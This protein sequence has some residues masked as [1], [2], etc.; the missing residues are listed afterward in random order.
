MRFPENVFD[1]VGGEDAIWSDDHADLSAETL[2][3]TGPHGEFFIKQGPVAVAEHERLRWLKRWASVPD[4]VAFEGDVLVLAEAG[5]RSLDH[6]PPPDAGTI[7][8]RALRELH[9]IPVAECPFDER[10]DVKLARAAGHVRA[11]LVD[12]ARFHGDHAGLTPEQVY[13]R[14]LAERPAGE[15]LVV[16]HGDFTPAN[17]LASDSGEAI[18]VDVGELGVADRHVDLA[19]AL[20]ELDG[21]AAADLLA[22]YGPA[23]VDEARLSYYRLLAELL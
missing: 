12:P 23:E 13:D 8:G 21:R 14:L 9:E 22:A 3:V 7:M 16:T 10:L 20:R 15:D 1:L 11:G 4:V 5:W 19:V 2:R 17:V 18:L 6:R